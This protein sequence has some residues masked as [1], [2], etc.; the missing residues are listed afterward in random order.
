M[1]LTVLLLSTNVIGALVVF[2]IGTWAIPSPSPNRAMTIA[3]AISIPVYVLLAVLVGTFW[4]T[5][6]ALKALRWATRRAWSRRPRS[7]RGR[8]GS[9]LADEMQLTM[10]LVAT[11]MVTLL[12]S[13]LQPSRAVGTGLTVGIGALVVAGVSYLLTEF[14]L[15][16]I[17]ARAPGRHPG[18]RPH[19]RRRPRTAH[20]DLLRARHGRTAPRAGD[21]GGADLHPRGR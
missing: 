5:T 2:A 20:D 9:H 12:T 10:W 17:A 4:G 11:A 1:L 6:T 7:A 19:P 21:R 13:L 18:H 3:L 14:S 8:C 15:R 16:P